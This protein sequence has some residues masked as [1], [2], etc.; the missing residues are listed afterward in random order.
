MVWTLPLR[1]GAARGSANRLLVYRL[2]AAAGQFRQASGAGERI[3]GPP[4]RR[5]TF[6]LRTPEFALGSLP[7]PAGLTARYAKPTV[8]PGTAEPSSLG[9]ELVVHR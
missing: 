8:D 6:V 9:D 5:S 7:V 4:T 3:P 2:S 1:A